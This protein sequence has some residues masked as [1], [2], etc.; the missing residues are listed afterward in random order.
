M[1]DVLC[2]DEDRDGFATGE[3][4][5]FGRCGGI[6]AVVLCSMSRNCFD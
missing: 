3:T 6:G 1:A 2:P 5:L 4:S